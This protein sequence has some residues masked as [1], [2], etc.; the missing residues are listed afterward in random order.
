MSL[1]A[2]NNIYFKVYTKV[3]TDYFGSVECSQF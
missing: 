2:A 1:T 3:K